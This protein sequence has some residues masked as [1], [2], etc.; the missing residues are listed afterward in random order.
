MTRARPP[1]TP[2]RAPATAIPA[3]GPRPDGRGR[4]RRDAPPW[5]RPQGSGRA[6]RRGGDGWGVCRERAGRGDPPAQRVGHGPS[7]DH[8]VALDDQLIL[9]GYVVLTHYFG[10]HCPTRY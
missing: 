2:R 3:T 9:P 7:N 5:R 10:L 1:G 8:I 4:W 6:G